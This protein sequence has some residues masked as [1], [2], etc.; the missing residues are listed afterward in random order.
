MQIVFVLL[1]NYSQLAC[2]SPFM[3]LTFYWKN[4]IAYI[5]LKLIF[6]VYNGDSV[7]N[8]LSWEFGL[9]QWAK[10]MDITGP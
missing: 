5:R 10:D 9:L 2:N 4:Y 7:Y 3:Q 8:G 6:Y 1:I